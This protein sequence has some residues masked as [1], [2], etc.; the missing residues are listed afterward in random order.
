MNFSS[1]SEFT[2]ALEGRL[3]GCGVSFDP[4][5]LVAFVVDYWPLMREDLDLEVWA[6]A[7]LETVGDALPRCT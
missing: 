2:A 7:F 4:V 6:W 3:Q 5:R 1:K